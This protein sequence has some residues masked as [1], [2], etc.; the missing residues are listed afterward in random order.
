[1]SSNI[2]QTAVWIKSWLIIVKS[3]TSPPLLK[4]LDPSELSLASQG[5]HT[6]PQGV[7]VQFSFANSTF[8][9][10]RLRF[11]V[12]LRCWVWFQF[13]IYFRLWFSTIIFRWQQ[14]IY[15]AVLVQV[16]SMN[17]SLHSHWWYPE[18]S[19]ATKETNQDYAASAHTSNSQ[20]GNH[21]DKGWPWFDVFGFGSVVGNRSWP[22]WYQDSH[23]I[24]LDMVRAKAETACVASLSPHVVDLWSYWVLYRFC[25]FC[26]PFA[27]SSC[28]EDRDRMTSSR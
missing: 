24:L 13:R 5:V 23:G 3:F 27:V 9:T 2:W 21:L 8:F 19:L 14:G 12:G 10:L 15:M 1:M 17:H 22:L 20:Q 26:I 4:K 11:G 16:K 18:V 28:A 7:T 6:F 25:A